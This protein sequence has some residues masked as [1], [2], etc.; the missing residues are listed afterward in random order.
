MLR[1]R[2]IYLVLLICTIIYASFFGGNIPYVLFYATL[3]IPFF[4]FFYT[5]YVNVRFKIYQTIPRVR[6][7]KKEIVPYQFV[8]A[9]EDYFTFTS[10]KAT[11][12]DE[13]SHVRLDSSSTLYCLGPRSRLEFSG[14]VYGDYRGTYNIGVKSLEIT[15]FL[16]L[17]RVNYPIKTPLRLIIS[18]R[19]LTLD[20]LKLTTF[21]KDSEKTRL[22]RSPI[23]EIV[24]IELRKYV[25]GDNRKLIH[26]KS[27][28]KKQELLTRKMTDIEEFETLLFIDLQ[29]ADGDDYSN[30]ISEDKI[31]ELALAITNHFFHDEIP[32]RIIY[33]N[34]SI[35]ELFIQ[36]KK[37][38]NYF[39]EQCNNFNFFGNTSIQTLLENFSNAHMQ[40]DYY[41]LISTKLT[42]EL[43]H[44]LF[45]LRKMGKEITFFYIRMQQ[46]N[47][48]KD[49]IRALQ[50]IGVTMHDI[51]MDED[52]LESFGA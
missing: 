10:I 34:G 36:E 30:F 6:F 24:D 51:W 33:E 18:P 21:I 3:S 19:I 47:S 4:C 25:K 16:E 1:N 40:N 20:N 35:K 37:D 11:F 12:F 8:L 14:S 50:E 15:D 29:K 41:I 2:I 28:A 39:Y 17:F 43:F 22:N 5:F 49:T 45:S 52:L 32:L 23:N 9:N 38:F 42:V 44:Q 27:S 7:A 31:I 46:D 48:T 13:K 26:W